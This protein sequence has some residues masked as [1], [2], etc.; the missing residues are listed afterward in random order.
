MLELH[1]TRQLPVRLRRVEGP[2]ASCLV[3]GQGESADGCCVVENLQ[4]LGLCKAN[5]VLMLIS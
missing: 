4:L 3:L 5:S 2:G 1:K